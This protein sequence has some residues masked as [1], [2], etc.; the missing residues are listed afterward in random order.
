M[1][2]KAAPSMAELQIAMQDPANY[3]EASK[4]DPPKVLSPLSKTEKMMRNLEKLRTVGNVL[5]NLTMV[6]AVVF[7]VSF[8]AVLGDR[9]YL[10]WT[11]TGSSKFE[12]FLKSHGYV[13]EAIAFNQQQQACKDSSNTLALCKGAAWL[14]LHPDIAVWPTKS[15]TANTLASA[16]NVPGGH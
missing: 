10:S 8:F 16:I 5:L 9:L 7:I 14:Y 13:N 2:N 3:P 12:G 11:D 6:V 4:Q 15:P 1:A